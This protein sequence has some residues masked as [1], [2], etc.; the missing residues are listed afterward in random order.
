MK[1]I[2]LPVTAAALVAGLLGG[3][4]NQKPDTQFSPEMAS[5]AN[6]FD[7]DPLLGPVK[8]FT[9][10]VIT[11]GGSVDRRVSATL[12]PQGCIETLSLEDFT[13]DSEASLVLDGNFYRDAQSNEPRISTQGTC[14]LA[15]I[16]ATGLRYITNDSDFIIGAS[17]KDL[18]IAYSYD[19]E[20]FPIGRIAR[21]ANDVL[22]TES[23]PLKDAK[24]KLDYQATMKEND[25]LLSRAEQRCEYDRHR[26]PT[27]CSLVIEPA[28]KAAIKY[29]IENTI[30]YY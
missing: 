6:E 5:F 2:V 11:S 7:F 22:T 30:D 27:S 9:Q 3:C 10:T 13:R 4:D 12:S 17:A 25:R 28:G 29:S 15:D 19:K 1:H 18:E 14:Q 26:N 21:Q 23:Q 20:G 8:S 24:G 16:P